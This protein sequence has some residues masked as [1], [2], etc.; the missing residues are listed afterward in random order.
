MKE[1]IT[2]QNGDVLLKGTLTKPDTNTSCPVVIVTHTSNAGTRD[3]GVYQHLTNL[4]PPLGIAVFLFD[5]RGSGESSGDFETASFF[6]L[7]ADA[8]AAIDHLKLRSDIDAKRIGVWGMSQGGWIAP[9]TASNSADIAFVIAVS[10][11]G[12]SPAEQMN[13]SAEYELRE[14]GFPEEAIRQMLDLHN[15]VNEYYRGKA[16]RSKAQEKLDAYRKEAWFPFAYL[17]DDLPQDPTVDKWHQEMDF[18]PLPIIQNV[19][20]P[21]LLLYGERDP[22]VPIDK[23]IAVWK[24]HGPDDLDIH[25]IKDANHF[26]ISIP[27]SG[28]QGDQGPQVEA[29]SAVLTQWLKQRLG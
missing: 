21:T 27:H 6:D 18:D 24:E 12:V 23:S 14:Q 15:L 17:D 3:F 8:Q 9:L 1:E 13:Y 20:V 22:W 2:F 19:H 5:R 25:Q 11:V 10:A 26:M 4:L 7:A 28:I 29:Y 16:D